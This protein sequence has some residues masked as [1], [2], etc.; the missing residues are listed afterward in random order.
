MTRFTLYL[1]LGLLGS[2]EGLGLGSP[3]EG[4]EMDWSGTTGFGLKAVVILLCF[5]TRVVFIG[6]LICCVGVVERR[7]SRN[8]PHAAPLASGCCASSPSVFCCIPR[9]LAFF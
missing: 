8:R 2:S 6:L 4:A 5:F 3:P 9:K 7:G 1:P